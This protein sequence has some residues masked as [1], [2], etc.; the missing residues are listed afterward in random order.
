MC[1][2]DNVTLGLSASESSAAEEDHIASNPTFV[3]P[4]KLSLSSEKD[5]MMDP[6]GADHDAL[7]MCGKIADVC[8]VELDQTLSN[9]GVDAVQQALSGE[10]SSVVKA[11]NKHIFGLLG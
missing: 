5:M 9:V 1:G 4:T 7:V 11:V 8:D 2:I 3:N 6:F 10:D